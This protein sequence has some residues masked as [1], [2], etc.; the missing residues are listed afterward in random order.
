MLMIN[1]DGS[2][3]PYEE[4][5]QQQVEYGL[6]REKEIIGDLSE[7]FSVDLVKSTYKYEKFD[8]SGLTGVKDNDG[9]PAELK[10][11]LKSRDFNSKRYDTCVLNKAKINYAKKHMIWNE[12]NEFAFVF[13]Y[14]DG[15]YYVNYDKKYL[16][17]PTRIIQNKRGDTSCVIDIELTDLIKIK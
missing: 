12:F 7:Y 8:F 11:E 1:I 2:V 5:K 16:T 6:R 14:T 3:I 9:L 4:L 10:I 17:Y 13:D 15:I